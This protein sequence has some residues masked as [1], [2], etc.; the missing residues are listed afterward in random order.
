MKK[1]YDVIP[2]IPLRKRLRALHRRLV[3]RRSMRKYIQ[4]SHAG[5][6]SDK[7]LLRNLIYGWGNEAWSALDEFL[8]ACIRHA[9]ITDGPILECGSGLT[10]L[11]VGIIARERG[12][13]H[14]ALEHDTDWAERVASELSH[15][16]LGN[17]SLDVHPL[18]DYGEYCWYNPTSEGL[19]QHFS[20]VICDGPPGSTKGGRAG[21]AREMIG[22]MK[23]GCVILLDDA[24]RDDE[25]KIGQR[26]E[27][28]LR[29][30]TRLVG[31]R[32]PYLK[33]V[34]GAGS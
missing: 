20:L 13:D 16:E 5:T 7:A 9:Q 4:E 6:R 11:L 27:K 25:M 10:T 3:F 24:V 23:D 19:P 32:A 31:Q 12:L 34:V 18:Q 14:I 29:A 30:S 2:L 8:S 17:V 21:L 22:R 28:E 33:L 15:Y 1:L 26:W